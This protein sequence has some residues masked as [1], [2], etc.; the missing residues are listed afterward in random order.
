MSFCLIWKDGFLRHMER[1]SMMSYIPEL[2]VV[3]AASQGCCAVLIFSIVR[4]LKDMQYQLIPERRLPERPIISP[5][6]GMS[7]MRYR[8]QKAPRQ[9]RYRLFILYQ[10]SRL[11]IYDL[12]PRIKPNEA[13]LEKLIDQIHIPVLEDE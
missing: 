4:N 2:S 7:W 5:I 3:I 13:V 8:P 11:L 9:L 10:N 6:A 12:I 1:F